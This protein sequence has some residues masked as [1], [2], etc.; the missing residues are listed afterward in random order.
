[1]KKKYIWLALDGSFESWIFD[2]SDA[3]KTKDDKGNDVAVL[4]AR[5]KNGR[6][7]LKHLSKRKHGKRM[8]KI[9]C[10]YYVEEKLV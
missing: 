9:K 4:I 8:T 3:L 2:A 1:M 7:Y 10:F 5:N 6:P